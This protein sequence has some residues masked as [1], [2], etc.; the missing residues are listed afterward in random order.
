M[1]KEVAYVS[2]I[3]YTYLSLIFYIAIGSLCYK[4]ADDLDVVKAT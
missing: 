2:W 1:C 3:G 4:L